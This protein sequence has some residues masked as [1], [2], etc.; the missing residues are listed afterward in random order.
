VRNYLGRKVEL[1]AKGM[2]HMMVGVD[3]VSDGLIGDFA[4]LLHV[5][6]Y[7]AGYHHGVD[8]QHAIVAYYEAG[9]AYV[10]SYPAVDISE[11]VGSDLL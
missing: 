5:H 9:V 7:L 3:H 2:V 8:N 4:Y 6:T 10:P 11:D 1:V